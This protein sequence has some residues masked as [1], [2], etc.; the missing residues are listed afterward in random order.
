MNIQ[1]RFVLIEAIVEHGHLSRWEVWA[2][3]AR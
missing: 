3:V 1:L 2:T